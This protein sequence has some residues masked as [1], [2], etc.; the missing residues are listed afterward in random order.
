MQTALVLPC[1]LLLQPGTG[2]EFVAV[3]WYAMQSVPW[4]LDNGSASH[5]FPVYDTWTAIAVMDERGD[6]RDICDRYGHV[7]RGCPPGDADKSL[8]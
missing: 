2:H 3:L 8:Y 6:E 1:G 5:C 4:N 7:L